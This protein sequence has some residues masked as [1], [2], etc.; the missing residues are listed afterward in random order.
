MAFLFFEESGWQ[1]TEKF[2]YI[3]VFWTE[4]KEFVTTSIK[5]AEYK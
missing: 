5:F 3:Y 2:L 4:T 1:K